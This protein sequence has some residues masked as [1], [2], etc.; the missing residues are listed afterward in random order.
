MDYISGNIF[1]NNWQVHTY[2]ENNDIKL[3]SLLVL[4]TVNPNEII[5][6]TGEE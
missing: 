6:G 2:P 3:L 4:K 1:P 5:S